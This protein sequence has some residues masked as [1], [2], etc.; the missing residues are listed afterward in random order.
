MPRRYP[1]TK[2]PGVSWPLLGSHDVS[3]EVLDVR[4][5][6]GHSKDF[7]NWTTTLIMM[8]LALTK[9]ADS[10]G[11]RKPINSLT[12]LSK[13]QDCWWGYMSLNFVEAWGRLIQ[14]ETLDSDEISHL[15]TQKQ[16]GWCGWTAVVAAKCPPSLEGA[17]F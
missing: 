7:K 17:G 12:V 6:S 8:V 4:S 9:V 11:E 1:K 16:A 15:I 5:F 13:G 3:L 10:S 14:Q 2:P